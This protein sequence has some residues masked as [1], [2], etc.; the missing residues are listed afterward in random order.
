MTQMSY[1]TEAEFHTRLNPLDHFKQIEQL[2]MSLWRT[3]NLPP[4]HCLDPRFQSEKEHDL[5]IFRCEGSTTC[6]LYLQE[7][8]NILSNSRFLRHFILSHEEGT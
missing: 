4:L 6:S 5:L 7:T 3:Q 8:E 1:S 2:R